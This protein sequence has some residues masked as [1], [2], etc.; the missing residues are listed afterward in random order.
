MFMKSNE[1][2]EILHLYVKHIFSKLI[3]IVFRAFSS[4]F[5]TTRH[6]MS[7]IHKNLIF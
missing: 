2:W 1:K 3:D 4:S 5:Q 6:K 7:K